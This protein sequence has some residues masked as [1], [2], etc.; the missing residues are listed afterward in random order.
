MRL[1]ETAAAVIAGPLPVSTAALG[2]QLWHG[3]LQNYEKM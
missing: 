1:A 3:F 2:G